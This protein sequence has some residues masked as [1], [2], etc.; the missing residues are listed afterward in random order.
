MADEDKGKTKKTRTVKPIYA[1]MQVKDDEGNVIALSKENVTILSVH[2]DA[3]EVLAKLDS[4]FA[5][6]TFYKRIAL[7]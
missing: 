7:G 3:E 6:G 4:G 5:P 2:K 1:I